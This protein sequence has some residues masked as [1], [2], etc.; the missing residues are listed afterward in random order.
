MTKVESRSMM[1]V[2]LVRAAAGEAT[3]NATASAAAPSPIALMNLIRG[4][5]PS[6]AAVRAVDCVLRLTRVARQRRLDH[7][8]IR[9]EQAAA[10][11]VRPHLGHAV[12]DVDGAGYGVA[13]DLA[14]FLGDWVYACRVDERDGAV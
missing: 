14:P 7:R 8:A 2:C 9:A 1:V 10:D 13:F 4:P 6:R 3:M 12:V 11:D 5:P